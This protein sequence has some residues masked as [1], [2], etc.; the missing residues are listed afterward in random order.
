MG[1]LGSH[2]GKGACGDVYNYEQDKVI[3]LFK[4]E[5]CLDSI[6]L[7]YRIGLAAYKNGIPTPEPLAFAKCGENWG[8]IFQKID[9]PTLDAYIYKFPWNVFSISRKFAKLHVQINRLNM[10]D[11]KSMNDVLKQNISRAK[12]LPEEIRVRFIKQLDDIGEGNQL[13]HADLHG[14]NIIVKN[15]RLFVLDW[16]NATIGY[17]IFDITHTYTSYAVSALDQSVP[18]LTRILITILRK[19][20]LRA[21]LKQYAKEINTISFKALLGTVKQFMPMLAVSRL[22]YCSDVE[23]RVIKKIIKKM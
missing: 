16:G 13:C 22:P 1:D 6:Q 8:I 19:Y 5:Q 20:Y 12:Q 23:M 9:G 21:Y 11:G 14:R 2:L 3:K 10:T 17:P 7:E 18:K 4:N 15:N